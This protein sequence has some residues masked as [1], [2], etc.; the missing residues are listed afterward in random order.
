YTYERPNWFEAVARE[1][2]AAREAAA[3]FD[4]TSFAKFRLSGPDAEAVLSEIT[5]NDVRK[6]HNAIIY[7]QL[8]N[9]AGGIEADLTIVRHAKDLFSLVT[10]TGFATHDFHWISSSIPPGANASLGDTTSQTAV[11]ALMGPK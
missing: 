9:D 10:G 1:H 3:L 2:R 6:K 7:T 5:A 11:L 8:L 4:Q